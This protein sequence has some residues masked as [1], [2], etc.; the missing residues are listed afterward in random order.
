MSHS[1]APRKYPTYIN[2]KPMDIDDRDWL[3]YYVR[4]HYPDRAENI[5]SS[6]HRYF[7]HFDDREWRK[8]RAAWRKYEAARGSLL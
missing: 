8:L 5:L 3:E 2:R 7:K 6:G 4:R 1:K